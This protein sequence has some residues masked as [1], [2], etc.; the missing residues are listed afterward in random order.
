MIACDPASART[1]RGIGPWVTSP[2]EATASPSVHRGGL[3]AF[4][5]AMV[6]P[7]ER[8]RPHGRHSG[9]V[10]TI[11]AGP[12]DRAAAVEAQERRVRPQPSHRL[13]APLIDESG[14]SLH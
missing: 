2:R 4:D 3:L 7:L 1:G 9:L 6:G 14:G 13:V 5:L 8:P 12:I 11:R 10:S